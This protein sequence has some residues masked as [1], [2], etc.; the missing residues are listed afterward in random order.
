[1]ERIEMSGEHDFQRRTITIPEAPPDVHHLLGDLITSSN[2]DL[3]SKVLRLDAVD[4]QGDY[5]HWQDMRYRTPPDGLTAEQWWTGTGLARDRLRRNQPMDDSNGAPFGLCMVDRIW[6]SLHRI[7]QAV[8]GQILV[9]D[10][11]ASPGSGDYYI[12]RS[13]IEEA[14]ASSQLEGA[15]T[16]RAIAKEMLLDGRDPRDLD[17]RMI[18]NNYAAINDV[19]RLVKD[20]A[21]FSVEAL[22]QLHRIITHD[23]LGDRS[24][25][26]RFQEPHDQRVTVVFRHMGFERTLHTPPPAEQLPERMQALCTFAN[27]EVESGF[28][29]PVIRALILHFWLA[30][31]HPFVDGNGRLARS[32]FYWSMLRSKYWLTEY[33]AISAI[34]RD[35][36][37]GYPEAFL[38]TERDNN[39]LTYFVLYQL[40]VIEDAIKRLE[41][42][43]NRKRR[44]VREAEA[45]LH[46]QFPFNHRQRSVIIVAIR[47]PFAAFYIGTHARRHDVSYLS[48]RTDLIQLENHGLLV[49]TQDGR[50][51]RFVAAP[52][53]VDRLRNPSDPTVAN[54][55]NN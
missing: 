16:T 36:P 15:S 24:D 55:S 7:D 51:I 41:Q 12:V 9:D 19:R 25:A 38:R 49:R 32:L 14:I 53:L 37:I 46:G 13:L 40:Q 48:A 6:E 52:N 1:M 28:M 22:K 3:L 26:G 11:V 35:D 4:E 5:L 23:T 17:E 31:D 33:L 43:L 2:E 20:E 47:D 10:P 29:H 54:P 44:E 50:L 34:L 42:Y 18:F 39:D 21:P 8:A 30:Y 45:H 27:G